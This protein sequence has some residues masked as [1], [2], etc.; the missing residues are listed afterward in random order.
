MADVG[1]LRVVLLREH[2]FWIAQAL[3][4]DIG[5]QGE[6]V[7]DVL[8]RFALAF[9][10]EGDAITTL[11]PAPPYFQALWPLKAGIFHP[12]QGVGLSMF[13]FGIVA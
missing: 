3:E 5:A 11:P 8:S 6:D 2:H 13:I 7:K 9:E 4:H 1:P 10:S 12:E